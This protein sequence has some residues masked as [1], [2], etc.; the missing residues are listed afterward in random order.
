MALW[1]AVHGLT[2]GQDVNADTFNRPLYELAERTNYLYGRLQTLVGANPYESIRLYDVP[3]TTTGTQAPAVKDVVY[4]DNVT[5]TYVKAQASMDL[6]D[7]FIA[8]NSAWA[9]GILIEKTGS[10]GT[11]L[12]SGRLPLESVGSPWT[13]TDLLET[14][15]VFRN[16][17]YYLSTMEAGKLTAAPS[18]P[19]I[20]VGYFLADSDNPEAGDY[21]VINPQYRDTGES[22][23]HRTY[24]LYTQPAGQQVITEETPSGIHYI[25]GFDSV[26]VKAGTTDYTDRVPRLVPLGQWTGTAPVEYT[27]WLA[28]GTDEACAISTAPASWSD[29]YLHWTSTDIDEAAGMVRIWSFESPVTI[30]THGLQVALENPSGYTPFEGTNWSVPYDCSGTGDTPDKRTWLVTAPT[31]TAG[32]RARYWRQYFEDHPAVDNKFSLLL[33]GGP[34]QQTDR[35]LA[36]TVTAK[37]A[38][39][40]QFELVLPTAG[41][42]T[43]IDTPGSVGYVFEYTADGT[44]SAVDH[45]PVQLAGDIYDPLPTYVNLLTAMLA[46]DDLTLTPVLDE[47]DLY[48]MIGTSSGATVTHLGVAVGVA[49]AGDGVISIGTADAALLVYD[50]YN[51]NLVTNYG[52]RYWSNAELWQPVAL[53]NQLQILLVPFDNDGSAETNE[54]IEL[55]DYWT[56]ELTDTAPG[57]NFVYA[58]GMHQSLNTYYPPVP[59][60]VASL[61]LNGVE[62]DSEM[63]FPTAAAYALSPDSIHWYS[64]QFGTVPWPIDWIDVDTVTETYLAQRLLLHFVRNS[65]GDTGYV[66]SLRSAVNSPI[67]VTQCGTNDAATTGDLMVDLDL[68]L[69]VED[70]NLSGYRVVKNTSGNKLQRGPVVEQLIAGPGI[71]LTQA[72]GAPSGQGKVT[73]SLAGN[74][75]YTGEFEEVALENAKQELIG[76]FPYIRLLGWEVGGTNTPTGFVAKFRVPHTVADAYYRVVVYATVF[77]EDDVVWYA[78]ATAPR[79]GLTFTYNILPDVYPIGVTTPLPTKALNL[80]ENLIQP[81]EA[82]SIA[83]PFGDVT[84]DPI[85]HGY[86]PMLVHNNPAEADV[87]GQKYRALGLPFPSVDDD[88]QGW[89]GMDPNQLGVR[90]GSL[91]AI[92][93]S[94]ADLEDPKLEYTGALGFINL[95]WMLVSL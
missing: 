34:H 4:L 42:T 38:E 9:V 13:L 86:D 89:D 75:Q 49:A 80:A 46:Q 69:Q 90:P 6:L 33:I 74:D 53:K 79:A 58:M 24:K 47:E 5:G 20:Y 41:D 39:I 31:A 14:G 35:R 57:A 95:R 12:V 91:V 85:Y 82:K 87:A 65:I 54:E 73:I 26:G 15:E 32:W 48:L 7:E 29:A 61:V 62:L 11:V 25:T 92:R 37:C 67:K 16:G 71:V 59:A 27:I 64:N 55:G 68:M 43:E 84:Q 76:M 30:G 88:P 23:V 18:G 51:R 66:T 1:V 21:A 77:G 50:Q 36:D 70:T 56:C 78:D 72:S 60:K 17:Q 40:H 28:N 83:I 81:A 93:I 52:T 8:A 2:D 94:R 45:I 22:H 63:L 10:T 44:V 19:M 3:L